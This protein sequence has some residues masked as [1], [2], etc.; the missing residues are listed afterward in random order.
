MDPVK[1][2]CGNTL[3]RRSGDLWI[4]T[5]RG[6]VTMAAQVLGLH[7]EQCGRDWTASSGWLTSKAAAG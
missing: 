6:R 2:P 5:Y 3:A 4:V 1:C 7:C